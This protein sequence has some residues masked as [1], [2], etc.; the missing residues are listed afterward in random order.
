MPRWNNG[1]DH[2]FRYFKYILENEYIEALSET[3]SYT[4]SPARFQQS[5]E[6]MQVTTTTRL[7]A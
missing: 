3:I 5:L 7:Q 4:Q 6:P 1:Y 2:R